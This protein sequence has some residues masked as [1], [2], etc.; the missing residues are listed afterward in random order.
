MYALFIITNEL[1]HAPL[2]PSAGVPA[3]DVCAALSVFENVTIPPTPMVTVDGMKHSGSHP[4]VEE[5]C[6][7]STVAFIE[8]SANALGAAV[9]PIETIAKRTNKEL[10]VLLFIRLILELDNKNDL[11]NMMFSSNI[12][13]L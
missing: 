2:G 9:I 5:P 1:S 6:A 13:L 8:C 7:F 11:Q 10:R 3:V 12:A 4:G